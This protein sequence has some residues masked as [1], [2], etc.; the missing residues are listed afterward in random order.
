MGDIFTPAA[1]AVIIAH[2]DDE[3]LWAG[4]TILLHPGWNW[5][6]TCLCRKSDPNRA[7]RFYKVL[8]QLNAQGD[9]GDLDDGPEQ[10]PLTLDMVKKTIL[11][12]LPYTDFDL[13]ITHSLRGE[14]T[15]H[16]RHWEVSRSVLELWQ[17][18]I[19]K[20]KQLW[21]FA[22]EDGGKDYFPRAIEAADQKFIIPNKIWEKKYNLITK[23]YGYKKSGFEARTTPKIEAFWCFTNPK[24]IDE[25]EKI[26]EIKK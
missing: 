26:E 12:L 6:I 1:T 2:P 15:K 22:Y 10:N 17:S 21:M 7:P 13:I 14:Y 19:L 4:G 18:G 16:R 20:A 25:I 23:T 5:Y 8:K 3:T 24:E 11:S 9:M